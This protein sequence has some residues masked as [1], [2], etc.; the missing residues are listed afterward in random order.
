MIS[1]KFDDKVI[2]HPEY[3]IKYYGT[4][5]LSADIYF[6][7]RLIGKINAE[8]FNSSSREFQQFIIDNNCD[9][10]DQKDS[11]L[12]FLM[13]FKPS[14]KIFEEEIYR[15]FS[16]SRD[17][18]KG[19]SDFN[20][21]IYFKSILIIK[22]IETSIRINRDEIIKSY[23]ESIDYIFPFNK[24]YTIDL[25]NRKIENDIKENLNILD[26]K[27]IIE[28]RNALGKCNSRY[29]ILNSVLLNYCKRNKIEYVDKREKGGCLWIVGGYELEKLMSL[30]REYNINFR[31]CKNGGRASKHREVWGYK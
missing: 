30:L 31:F 6:D 18:I 12:N 23:I 2:F 13:K 4:I 28:L 26:P 10:K 24:F 3:Y 15:Q 25:G 5:D 17:N 7:K 14:Y 11:F 8:F 22:N 21:F 27:K 16:E 1:F 9:L 20:N 19:N 29:E